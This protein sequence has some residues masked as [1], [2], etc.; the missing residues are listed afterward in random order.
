MSLIKAADLYTKPPKTGVGPNVNY[1]THALT[2]AQNVTGNIVALGI[3]PARH[4]L[5]DLRLE[6]DGLDTGTALV[7]NVGIL[8]TYYNEADASVTEPAAYD[9][10]GATNTGTAPALVSG[11]NAISS[12]TIG[13]SSAVG[14]EGMSAAL[15]PSLAIGVDNTKDRIIAVELG[16]G[17]TTDI[18]GDIALIYTTAED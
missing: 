1:R 7:L 11:H 5:L 4:R 16:T 10:G 9:S 14:S 17:S 12:A 18:A 2:E 3:L 6:V 13:R 15:N 8:N